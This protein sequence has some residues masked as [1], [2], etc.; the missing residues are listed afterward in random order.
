MTKARVNADNASA[1]IQGVTAGTGL[2]GGGT[3]GTVTLT[4]GMATAIDAKGDLVVG[5]GADTFSRLAAGSNGDTIVADASTAT[6]L[7]YQGTIAAGRNFVIG[8]GFDIWQRGTTF[9]SNGY[10]AD[11]WTSIVGATTITRQST[12]APVGSQY[13][14]RNTA[15]STGAAADT[16]SYLETSQI[17]PLVGRTVTLSVKVRRNATMSASLFVRIDK[18]PTVDAGSGA[19]WTNIT[20]SSGT[21][22]TSNETPNASITT[23]TGAADWTTI[24]RTLAIPN[25][26]TA[27]SLRIIIYQ[28]AG[29]PSGSVFDIAQVQLEIGS[30]ATNFS[31]AGGTIQGELAACQRYYQ[32]I[33]GTTNSFPLIG[34]YITNG[35]TLRVP[36]V[37]PVQMRVA[38]TITKNGT[39]EAVGIGQP[40]AVYNNT[41]GFSIQAVGTAN[42][43]YL[44]PNSTDDSFTMSAEL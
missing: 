44:H 9:T 11:R 35:E 39:W 19:T 31:R 25:D 13:Y 5:T 22:G 14:F 8:G 1:D 2:T 29:L 23:G 42:G 33:G 40:S 18:S 34:G 27:N 38:P 20:P 12:N 21:D 17:A 30:V 28:G 24:T 7:R 16:Y 4:N 10:N 26:G 41:Q 6:G 15:T 3:S 37:F 32:V 43:Y 36:M